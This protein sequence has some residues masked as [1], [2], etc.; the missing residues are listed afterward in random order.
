MPGKC[1]VRQS[2]ARLRGSGPASLPELFAKRR[3]APARGGML[4]Q[5]LQ[6]RIIVVAL[7]SVS[8]ASPFI[9][10]AG[11]TFRHTTDAIVP[12]ETFRQV[13][14]GVFDMDDAAMA[15]RDGL[16]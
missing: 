15:G 10:A 13:F 2:R 3:H 16:R 12:L 11:T 8:S 9:G 7:I 14:A 5:V 6:P 1:R 4:D